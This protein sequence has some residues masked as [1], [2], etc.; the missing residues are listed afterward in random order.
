MPIRGAWRVRRAL[1]S[2]ARALSPMQLGPVRRAVRLVRPSAVVLMYHRVADLDGDVFGLAVRPENF[3]QQLQVIA[4]GYH[5]VRVS[6]LVADVGRRAIPRRTVAVTFDDGYADNHSEALPA[7]RAAGVPATMYIV[8]SSVGSAAEY[9]WD[10]LELLA[11]RRAATGVHEVTAG[12]RHFRLGGTADEHRASFDA[13]HRTMLELP[14]D[15]Q[16]A[17][18]GRLATSLGVPRP[19]RPEYRVMT[20]AEVEEA[21]ADPLVEIGAH[22]VSHAHLP[23]RGDD[24]LRTEV[25]GSRAWLMERLGR[26][27]ESLSYPY[28]AHDERVVAAAARS[29]FTSA[30]TIDATTL[31]PGADPLRL[32]RFT[33]GDWDGETFERRLAA[34]F[35]S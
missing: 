32:G 1:R 27:I 2:G 20:T 13:L 7:L 10:E 15:E 5:A 22:T 25:S 23:S 24:E 8:T 35:A 29:G 14:A 16:S 18:L 6:D 21:G 34:F 9:W 30:V 26:G 19:R 3:R 31:G 11:L 4:D 12:E 17:V 28:G 33:V